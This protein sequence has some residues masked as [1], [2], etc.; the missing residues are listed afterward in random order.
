M[1]ELEQ[2]VAQARSAIAATVSV[3]GLEQVKARYLG[4]AG[5]LTEL[6]KGLGKLE[7][8]RAHV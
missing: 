6:L 2:L 4:K 8:G 1:Q 5:L 7:I 3:A